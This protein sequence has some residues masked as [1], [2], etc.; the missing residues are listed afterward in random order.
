MRW[1]IIERPEVGALGIDEY[2]RYLAADVAALERSARLAG[3]DAAVPSCP[4]WDVRR[5]LQHTTKV[6]HFATWV[7]QGGDREEFAF[8]TPDDDALFPRFA[9][10]A[11]GLI[12]ALGS[13]PDDLAVWTMVPGLPARQFWARRQAHETTVHR[14]DAE[15]AAGFGVTEIAADYADDGLAELLTQLLPG[16]VKPAATGS[17]FRVSF[18][19]LDANSSWT[20]TAG[21]SGLSSSERAS[22]DAD[23]A[24][25]GMAAD[26]YRWAWNRAGDDEVSLRGDLTLAD[27]WRSAFTVGAR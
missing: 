18:T 10:G 20:V 7:V 6:H 13:A 4:R 12:S 2:L 9:S 8:D 1:R 14:I 24:V 11:A 25:F 3:L 27:T 15:L 22:D 5:L 23:L 21:P 16:R 17:S 26:L 19:P